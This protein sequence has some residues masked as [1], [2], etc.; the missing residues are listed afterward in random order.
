MMG[1]CSSLPQRNINIKIIRLSV[2]APSSNDCYPYQRQTL[3]LSAALV[4]RAPASTVVSESKQPAPMISKLPFY[5]LRTP[6]WYLPITA[7]PS[8]GAQPMVISI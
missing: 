2:S 5:I 8:L 1:L 7:R 4:T 3:W 6:G